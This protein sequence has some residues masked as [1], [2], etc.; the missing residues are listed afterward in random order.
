MVK[1]TPYLC[2][3]ITLQHNRQRYKIHQRKHI[4]RNLYTLPLIRNAV[5]IL[6]D[7]DMRAGIYE[8]ACGAGDFPV[9]ALAFEVQL[10]LLHVRAP[11]DFSVW[12]M[13]A[14]DG[15]WG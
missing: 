1:N 6:V 12:Q 11:V 4:L 7:P 9:V 2:F 3:P 15:V 13:L 10:D 8:R 5:Q 14:W